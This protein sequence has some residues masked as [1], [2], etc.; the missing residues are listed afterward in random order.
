MSDYGMVNQIVELFDAAGWDRPKRRDITEI[1]CTIGMI[2]GPGAGEVREAIRWLKEHPEV[3][4]RSMMDLA[5]WWD[6][7]IEI[8]G[9][10][11]R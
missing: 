7:W 4:V 6:H 11:A 5:R 1:V 2:D 3:P 10:E 9:G 8:R